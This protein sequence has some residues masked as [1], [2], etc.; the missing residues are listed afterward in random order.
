MIGR[1]AYRPERGF[2]SFFSTESALSAGKG[3]I[4]VHSAGE[5][6]YL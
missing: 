6:Y 1:I 3:E 2:L 4:S 5:V